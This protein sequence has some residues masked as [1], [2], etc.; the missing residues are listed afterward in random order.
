MPP[1]SV[2]HVIHLMKNPYTLS[3]II[4]FLTHVSESRLYQARLDLFHLLLY[5]YHRTGTP[6]CRW[7]RC[8]HHSGA[9]TATPNL[10]VCSDF[11]L[12]FDQLFPQT[13][14]FKILM[15]LGY[16]LDINLFILVWVL[17]IQ[18]GFFFLFVVFSWVLV[19]FFSGRFKPKKN[20]IVSNEFADKESVV[21]C[22]SKLQ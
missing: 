19:G 13:L 6:P 8:T 7:R 14:C 10:K 12:L 15:G 21:S 5:S 9:G 2:C 16:F 17:L 18:Y 22:N 20:L 3:H 4:L 11:S 1:I